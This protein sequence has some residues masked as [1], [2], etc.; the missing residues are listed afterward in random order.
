MLLGQIAALVMILP[1]LFAIVN[2][3]YLNKALKL[4][5]WFSLIRLIVSISVQIIIWCVNKYKD[6][7]IPIL[8]FLDINSLDCMSIFAHLNYFGILGWYFYLVM[9]NRNIKSLVKGISI[10]LFI[11]ALVNYLFIEGYKV[12]SVF[13]STVA[14][15]FCFVLPMIHLWY[16]Y[17]QDSKVPISKNPYNWVSLG[18][19]IPNLL[20]LITSLFGKKLE[21][22]DLTLYLQ[23]EIAYSILQ[24]IGYILITIGFYYARYTKYMPKPTTQ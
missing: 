3:R 24:I 9:E 6:F 1:I 20:G 22:T 4:M 5:F 14:N 18:L 23:I 8:K 17:N 2:L 13:N 21:E 10:S 11:A 16:L 19:V 12:Q 15:I 7:F